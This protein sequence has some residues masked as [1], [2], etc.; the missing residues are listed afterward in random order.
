MS[1][2]KKTIFAILALVVAL[3]A[4]ACSSDATA[5]DWTD[6]VIKAG[7]SDPVVITDDTEKIVLAAT[8]GNCRLR[9][10]GDKEPSRLYVTVPGSPMR[11]EDSY[12]GDPSLSLLRRD[13]RFA[14]CFSEEKQS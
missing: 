13:K 1:T 4:T 3:V 2:I 7:F 11:E 9:F 5:K 10:V 8:G 12:V 14:D 6:E